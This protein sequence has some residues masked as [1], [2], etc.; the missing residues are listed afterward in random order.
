MPKIEEEVDETQRLFDDASFGRENKLE[1]TI[2]KVKQH[3]LQRLA[4]GQILGLESILPQQEFYHTG[5]IC[6]SLEG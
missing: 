2:C 5:A 1:P 4:R 6:E 3:T